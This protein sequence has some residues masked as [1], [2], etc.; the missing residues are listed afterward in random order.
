MQKLKKPERLRQLVL[1]VESLP[2]L[3]L[4]LTERFGISPRSLTMIASAVIFLVLLST[5]S[6]CAPRV[7]KPSLPAQADP[8]PMPKFKG[9]TYRDALMHIPELREAFLSCEADKLAIR[10]ALTDE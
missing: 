3:A 1:L 6:G 8:R 10:K 4:R 2:L 7:V 5:L 9:K